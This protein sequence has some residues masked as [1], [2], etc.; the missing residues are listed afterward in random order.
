MLL[1]K[2][3]YTPQSREAADIDSDSPSG[4]AG[5][6]GGSS[7][8]H[9]LA[10]WLPRVARNRPAMAP[11]APACQREVD[12]QTLLVRA[13]EGNT[14]AFELL[15]DRFS[16]PLFALVIRILGTRAETEDVLQEGLVTVWRRAGDFNPA[17]GSAFAWISTIVRHKAIDALRA[18]SRHLD[19][20][21]SAY[22]GRSDQEFADAADGQAV[23]TEQRQAIRAAVLH[24]TE[25]EGRAIE[26]AFFDGL[27]HQEIAD[28]LRIPLG[29]VKARIRRGML[30][31]RP[32][33]LCFSP[34][35]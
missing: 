29:T 7:F 5:E 19:R 26:L 30:K 22:S 2:I 20:L 33:L 14:A 15:Y 1:R 31:L 13:A 16:A 17:L 25:V 9:R 28:G 11:V 12:G 32:A 6:S 8:G 4:V 10:A 34:G 21:Q 18:K 35:S 24:L 3:S 23:M 27:T